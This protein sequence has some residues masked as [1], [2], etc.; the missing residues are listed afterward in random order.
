MNLSHENPHSCGVN[1]SLWDLFQD[2]SE[3]DV[4]IG[5]V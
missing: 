3:Q 2:Q 1:F 4:I 5:Q